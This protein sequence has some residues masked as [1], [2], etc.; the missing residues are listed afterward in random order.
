MFK[1]WICPKYEKNPQQP[2]TSETSWTSKTISLYKILSTKDNTTGHYNATT[3]AHSSKSMRNKATIIIA[4]ASI[5]GIL[6]F[7]S[8]VLFVVCLLKSRRFQRLLAEQKTCPHHVTNN[9]TY[10][11]LVVTS[12][13]QTITI[14]TLLFHTTNKQTRVKHINIYPEKCRSHPLE[15]FVLSLFLNLHNKHIAMVA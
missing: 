9:T 8:I 6:A 5:A 2:F 13:R 7:T 10:D 4:G 14:L 15:C 11:N 3:Y 1:Y 12:Q